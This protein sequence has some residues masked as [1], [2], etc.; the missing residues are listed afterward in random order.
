MIA[1]LESC[2]YVT[3]CGK[4]GHLRIGDRIILGQATMDRR[5]SSAGESVEK[6]TQRTGGNRRKDAL[7][8]LKPSTAGVSRVHVA[9]V[10]LARAHRFVADS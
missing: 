10:R 4:G 3:G 8:T 5:F 7:L 2:T 1:V 6:L 9:S